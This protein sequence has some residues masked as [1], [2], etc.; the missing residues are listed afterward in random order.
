MSDQGCCAP[1]IP[2]QIGAFLYVLGKVINIREFGY[3]TWGK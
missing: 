2:G 3:K 1:G